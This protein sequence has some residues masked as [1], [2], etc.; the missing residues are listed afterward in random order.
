MIYNKLK[1]VRLERGISIS[2]LARRAKLNRIT[3]SNIENRESNP[4]QT[5]IAAI[6]DVLNRDPSEIFFTESVN[7]ELQKER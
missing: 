4:T 1:E 7:R 3:I 2:E 5:T 6:C